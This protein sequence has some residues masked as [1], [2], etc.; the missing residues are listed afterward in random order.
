[1]ELEQYG[2]QEGRLKGKQGAAKGFTTTMAGTS[3]T[4]AAA[5]EAASSILDQVAGMA[6]ECCSSGSSP[7]TRRQAL[8]DVQLIKRR[9][10]TLS[11]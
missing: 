5:Q 7:D 9:T 3:N 10:F 6:A 2:W 4:R 1:V 8:E 11:A